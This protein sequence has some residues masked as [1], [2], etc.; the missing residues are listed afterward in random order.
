VGAELQTREL[1][2]AGRPV[3]SYRHVPGEPPLADLADAISGPEKAVPAVLADLPGWKVATTDNVLAVMLVDA[4]CQLLRYSHLYSLD[5]R[6]ELPKIGKS[7]EGLAEKFPSLTFTSVEQYATSPSRWDE[8]VDLSLAA[9]PEGHPDAESQ[10][11]SWVRGELESLISG[12]VIGPLVSGA[13][14]VVLMDA[15]LA[16]APASDRAAGLLI[17]NEMPG[18]PPMGGP[19]VSEVCRRPESPFAGLGSLLLMRAADDLRTA[20]RAT[21]SLVVTD[22]NP[23]RATYERLGFAFVTSAWKVQVP[24]VASNLTSTS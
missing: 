18:E 7:A 5:L 21:L 19:W 24:G 2:V 12:S 4:G 1:F 9:Y 20:G 23:A 22:G 17:V 6:V 16:D 11:R 15:S 8:L 14:E 3:L 13:S 10:D